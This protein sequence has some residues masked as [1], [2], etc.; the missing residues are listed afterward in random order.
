MKGLRKYLTPFA[1][2]QSG[3]VSVLYELGGIIVIVDA[4]GCVGNICGFDEPRWQTKKSAIFSAGLRDMDAIM[5]RDEQLVRKLVMAANQVD[6]NFIAI[7]GTP[8]PSVIGTD[9]Y[10]LTRMVERKIDLPVLTIDTNGMELY[11]KGASKAY[12]ELVKKFARTDEVRKNEKAIGVI[13]CNPLDL[14]DL[15]AAEKIREFFETGRRDDEA[16]EAVYTFGMD[17]EF[18]DLEKAAEVS[19]NIVVSNSGIQAARLL[20]EKAGIPYELFDPLAYKFAE[21]VTELLDDSKTEISL[22][23]KKIL[24]VDG[25]ISANTMRD[26]FDK[27][28]VRDSVETITASWFAMDKTLMREDDRHLVEEDHFTELVK[29]NDIVVIIAD[30]VHRKMIRDYDG[31][32]IDKNQFSLSGKLID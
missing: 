27:Y 21:N 8:V 12:V 2:D 32:F 3:A 14:S 9:Y 15:D 29:E 18:L 20:E 4:G 25:Q 5:G 30:P 10:A 19:K 6:A 11:D 28:F 24:V 13:G 22:K 7:I 31:M 16:Y 1:P 23:G 26:V 17:S